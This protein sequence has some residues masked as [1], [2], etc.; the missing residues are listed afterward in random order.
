MGQ[1]NTG[2]PGWRRLGAAALLLAP[3]FASGQT[4]IPRPRLDWRRIGNSSQ[5]VGL[6]SP[7][8]GPVDRVWFDT[9]GRLSAMLPDSRTFSTSDLETWKPLTAEPPA[10]APPPAGTTTPEGGVRLITSRGGLVVYAAG[11][12][13]WRSEDGGLNWTNL[14]AYQQQSLLGGEVRDL[15]VDPND[16]QRIAA[17]TTSGVW[18]S[19]DAGQSWLGLND[20]LPNLPVRRILSAPAGTRGLRIAVAAASQLREMEWM[21]GQT[22]GWLPSRESSLAVEQELRRAIGLQFGTEITAVAAVGE[23]VYAGTADGR[24]LVSLDAAR[25]WRS[26]AAPGAGR[27]ERIMTDPADREFALAA[28]SGTDG[29]RLLR[30]L[31]AGGFWDDLTANLPAG[32]SYGVAA[33]RA[34]GGLYLAT[35]TGLYYTVADLRAPAPATVWTTLDPGLPAGEV[36][37]VRLD[38]AGN[39]LLAAVEGH[40]VY[41]APAP[42]RV[43]QPRVVHTFD[44]RDRAAAPGAL[45]SVLGAQVRSATV[46]QRSVPVLDANEAESQIQIPFEA[47]GDTLQLVVQSRQGRLVFGLP[48]QDT[49]PVVLID[50]DGTPMLMDGDSGVQ[51]DAMHPAHP[52]TRVQVL[53]SGLGRVQPDWPTGMAAPLEDAPRVA[54]PLR[55]TLNGASVPVVRATLAPGLIGYYLVEVQL[56]EFVDSGAG[57]LVLEAA[58][59]A[60]NRVRVYLAQ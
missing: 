39:V 23:A 25:N 11:R 22:S 55:A 19:V 28:L 34:T 18:L 16:N 5:V 9:G 35:A 52:G 59:K 32:P 49:A 33:D 36:R 41:A 29:P 47:T 45:V 46:N 60:S 58:G 43:R 15:A 4:L 30:T 26:F 48:L 57:E 8:G 51:L 54:A 21:P 10:V 50:R 2:W 44:M 27:V 6:A 20:G 13:A 1:S 42:H 3:L 17:A 12:H 56:P 31:N 40:G 7:A 37:D 24:M 53:M 38:D 14:T